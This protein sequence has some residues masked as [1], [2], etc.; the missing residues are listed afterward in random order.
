VDATDE[1][2]AAGTSAHHGHHATNPAA[3]FQTQP[4]YYNSPYLKSDPDVRNVRNRRD[5]ADEVILPKRY[6]WH[7]QQ[8]QQQSVP[9]F[10]EANESN[11]PNNVDQQ[12]SNFKK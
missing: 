11:G 10:R 5:S 2:R 1:D 4:H 9:S 6:P 7:H 8:L 12:S 3:N